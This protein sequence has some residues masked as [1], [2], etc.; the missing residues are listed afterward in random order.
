VGRPFIEFVHE[1]V[2]PWHQ[3]GSGSA[4][5]DVSAR[6]L[7]TDADTGASSQVVQYPPGWSRTE[8]EVLVVDEELFVLTGSLTIGCRTYG[9]RSYAFLPAGWLRTSASSP[10]GALVLTFFTGEPEAVVDPS[11]SQV[12]HDTTRVVEHIDAL[13]GEWGGNFHPSF[14]PGAGRKW[15]RRDPVTHEETWILG[16][17]P[18]RFGLRPEKH[19]VVEEMFLLSGQLVG[20]LGK[21]HAG[22]YF[23]RPEEEWH[24]PF[25]SLTGNLMLFR[26][27]GGPLS[28]VYTEDE[29]GF[30]WDPE[31]RPIL[32]QE[33]HSCGH[34][35]YGG[36]PE[37]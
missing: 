28:T 1:Q 37:W 10:A 34:L 23:W 16:T 33:L 2:L 32:P 14:P 12:D 11:V 24:G 18:L 8:P 19:P 30:S 27:L 9:P 7:S 21:M 29:M 31:H 22:S 15:L 13:D 25:G 26:T 35:P 3:G 4:R 36:P 5:P 6:L 17:M 20:P